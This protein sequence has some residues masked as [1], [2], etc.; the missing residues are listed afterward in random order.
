MGI[1]VCLK[2]WVPV[3]SKQLCEMQRLMVVYEQ[4]AANWEI[5]ISQFPDHQELTGVEPQHF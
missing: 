3:E 4:K 1:L 5:E 2:V